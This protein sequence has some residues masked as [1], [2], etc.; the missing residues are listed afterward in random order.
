MPLLLG[1]KAIPERRLSYFD[2]PKLNG[3]KK[4]RLQVFEGNGTVGVDIFEHGNGV[5]LMSSVYAGF[6]AISHRYPPSHPP[7]NA[8]RSE[9]T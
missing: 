5:R 6:R 9:M 8:R 3:G 7:L 1:R 2:D 4:S